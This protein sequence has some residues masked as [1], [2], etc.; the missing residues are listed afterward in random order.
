MK[1][2]HVVLLYMKQPSAPHTSDSV[3][4][5]SILCSGCFPGVGRDLVSPIMWIGICMCV[6]VFC[7]IW[8]KKEKFL[9]QGTCQLLYKSK[10]C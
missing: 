10:L 8:G 6:C 5:K 4:H 9:W 1:S 7:E 3:S 2:V